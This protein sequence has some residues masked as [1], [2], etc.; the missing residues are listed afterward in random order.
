V[1][2]KNMAAIENQGSIRIDFESSKKIPN[3][4]TMKRIS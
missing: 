3:I 2:A 1:N 4:K